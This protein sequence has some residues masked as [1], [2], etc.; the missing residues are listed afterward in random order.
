RA[1]RRARPA[2]KVPWVIAPASPGRRSRHFA[3]NVLGGDLCDRLLE[4][5]TALERL[6]LLAGPGAVL[7]LLRPCREISGGLGFG[8]R[9]HVAADTDLPAQRL[10]VKQ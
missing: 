8:H 3:D 4:R 9:R 5:K 2:P 10:P 6:R 7:G 1:R